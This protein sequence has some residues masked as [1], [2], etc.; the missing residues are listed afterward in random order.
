ML[1]SSIRY[2][3]VKTIPHS[4]LLLPRLYTLTASIAAACTPAKQ[5]PLCAPRCGPLCTV[6]SPSPP[7][8]P[9]PFLY[10]QSS[11][12]AS[13]RPS[14][15]SGLEY[16]RKNQKQRWDVEPARGRA[17]LGIEEAAVNARHGCGGEGPGVGQWSD[18]ARW[19]RRARGYMRRGL[20]MHRRA[21]ARRAG[22]LL[23]WCR[24]A[25]RSGWQG[26]V[27]VGAGTPGA[28]LALLILWRMLIVIVS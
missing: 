7:A 25:G 5:Y 19:Q 8:L 27:G 1:T 20:W 11:S 18:G 14:R 28:S 6:S 24:M 15:R 2:S 10:A 23:H 17:R 3:R 4:A 16:P 13:S 12:T 21:H 26:G 9:R 22:K